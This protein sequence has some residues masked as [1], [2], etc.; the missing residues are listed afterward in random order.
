MRFVLEAYQKQRSRLQI[1]QLLLLF[2]RCCILMF[3]G[4]AL[5]G[6]MLPSGC[7][8]IGQEKRVVHLVIDDSLAMQ[9]DDQIDFKNRFEQAKSQAVKVVESLGSEDKVSLTWAANP[10]KT[11]YLEGTL[12]HAAIIKLI[13]LKKVR[14]SQSQMDQ[15]IDEVAIAIKKVEGEKENHY[16]SVFTG[17]T[18]NTVSLN[19]ERR[20]KLSDVAKQA[21]FI[22]SKPMPEVENYQITHVTPDWR[23]QIYLEDTKKVSVPVEIGLKRFSSTNKRVKSEIKISVYNSDLSK[24]IT[25]KTRVYQWVEGQS[26]DR[27][28]MNLVVPMALLET[29]EDSS[30]SHFLTIKCVI[31]NENGSELIPIDNLRYT[32]VELKSMIKVVLIDDYSVLPEDEKLLQRQ[33]IRLA[34]SPGTSDESNPTSFSL[35]EVDVVGLNADTLIGADAIMVLKPDMVTKKQWEMLFALAVKGK[36]IWVHPTADTLDSSWG[37]EF[38]EAFKLDW[39]IALETK[40]LEEDQ[41]PWE[42][43]VGEVPA[44]LSRLT[45]DWDEL[46]KPIKIF[47]EIP[48]TID[49]KSVVWLKDNQSNPMLIQRKVG[50]GMLY[51]SAFAIED[52]WT[53][54][55]IKYLYTALYHET[56]VTTLGSLGNQQIVTGVGVNEKDA[57]VVSG[58]AVMLGD[59][60]GEIKQLKGQGGNLGILKFENMMA[61]VDKPGVYG[62]DNSEQQLKLIVN[63]EVVGGNTLS[64]SEKQLETWFGSWGKD[65]WQWMDKH[66]PG[67]FLALKTS[68]SH[69]MQWLLWAMLVFLLIE[70]VL[71]RMFSHAISKQASLFTQTLKTIRGSGA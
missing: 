43:S 12:D 8:F 42:L 36:M 37:G 11:N 17:F 65:S 19:N 20:R 23:M 25:E 68:N 59:R 14:H 57:T 49:H 41:K 7:A 18:K 24:L 48:V 70:L 15:A 21:H 33:W 31:K 66:D 22:F 45:L 1:E 67:E 9:V 3:L 46:L 58:F 54:M 35:E 10:V 16:V 2:V 5:A 4:L 60:W 62:A 27:I 6:M 28:R 61:M 34:L 32:S 69:L 30:R 38:S 26:S 63:P 55:M 52:R 50:K 39:K 56:I 29:D 13:N 71:A 44:Q 40:E 53:N 51:F 47:R 64:L